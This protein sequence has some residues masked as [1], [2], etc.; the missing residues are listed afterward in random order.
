MDSIDLS[1]STLSDQTFL[2]KA[3]ILQVITPALKKRSGHAR[4]ESSLFY[5][6]G[7]RKGPSI[8]TLYVYMFILK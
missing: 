3:L 8:F 2:G 7:V 4:L 6:V 1:M 5:K